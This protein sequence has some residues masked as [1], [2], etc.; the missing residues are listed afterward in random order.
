MFSFLFLAHLFAIPV[1]FQTLSLFFFVFCFDTLVLRSGQSATR[2]ISEVMNLSAGDLGLL[3]QCF[4]LV[5]A[6]VVRFEALFFL[7]AVISG[8]LIKV[9]SEIFAWMT[10]E[11]IYFNWYDFYLYLLLVVALILP[12]PV[13]FETSFL[14][15]FIGFT[16]TYV[17]VL[18]DSFALRLREV[19]C[20]LGDF[21]LNG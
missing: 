20:F 9:K 1:R 15:Q 7:L 3:E 16:Q 8:A 14:Q 19:E 11:V 2:G 17:H 21:L 5:F 10:S 6:F 18:P 12:F 13:M 4:A